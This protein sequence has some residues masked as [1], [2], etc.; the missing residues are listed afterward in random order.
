MESRFPGIQASARPPHPA[1]RWQTGAVAHIGEF[2]AEAAAD[3][4]IDHRDAGDLGDIRHGT[5]R[6]GVD[7]DDV[8]FT[9]GDR[10]LDVDQTGDVELTGKAELRIS[11]PKSSFTYG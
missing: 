8:H 1:R 2:L 4:Q 10:I 5:G 7:L 3:G 11:P 9:V 6:A